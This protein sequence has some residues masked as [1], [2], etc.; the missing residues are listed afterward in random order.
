MSVMNPIC[1]RITAL[2][3]LLGVQ[4]LLLGM[5]LQRMVGRSEARGCA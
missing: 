3:E 2:R 4:N 1:T 5:G